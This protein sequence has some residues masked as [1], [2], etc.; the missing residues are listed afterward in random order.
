MK[1]WSENLNLLV[2]SFKHLHFSQT[3]GK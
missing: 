3:V 1:L 2:K